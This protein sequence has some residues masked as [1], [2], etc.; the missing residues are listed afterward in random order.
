MYWWPYVKDSKKT[1]MYNTDFWTLWEMVKVGQYESIA[2]KY[3]YDQ[4][5]DRWPNARFM[6]SASLM[7]EAGHSKLVPLGKPEGWCGVGG[8]RRVQDGGTHV[9]PWLIHVDVWQKKHHDIVK[10]LASN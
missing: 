3:V 5:Q 2:L 4:M 9:H 10:W 6:T 1:K 7:Y 8:G